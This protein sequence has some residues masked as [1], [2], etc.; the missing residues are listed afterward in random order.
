MIRTKRYVCSAAGYHY[1]HA[2]TMVEI[3]PPPGWTNDD[4]DLSYDY[5]W[6]NKDCDGQLMAKWKGLADP[7]PIMCSTGESG[8]C[9]YMF[10][11]GTK[12]YIWNE[13]EGDVWKIVSPAKLEDILDEISQLGVGRLDVKCI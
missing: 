3:T 10:Q 5:Y 8:G 11:S 9:L 1:T 6:A 2:L 4:E 12:Y 7:Q 13:I